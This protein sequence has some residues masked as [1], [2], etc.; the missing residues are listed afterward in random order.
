MTLLITKP[1]TTNGY[2]TI[3]TGDADPETTV[4]VPRVT[5]RRSTWT[6]VAV[7]GMLMFSAGG[8]VWRMQDVG[9]SYNPSSG[10]YKTEEVPG[11]REGSL[12]DEID[13]RGGL[14]VAMIEDSLCLVAPLNATFAGV[15]I[16]VALEPIS[17][18]FETCWKRDDAATYCW[19]RSP[20][21]D[22]GSNLNYWCVPKG[23]SKADP[24]HSI[25]TEDMVNRCDAPC[26]K[27]Y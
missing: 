11:R 19:S 2:N 10:S 27:L 15:S 24:W 12:P 9:S 25:E 14:V 13:P 18:P 21:Y 5:A 17:H 8:A 20:Q 4:T 26:Q 6:T 23:G 3:A 7:A 1:P 22:G 16:T